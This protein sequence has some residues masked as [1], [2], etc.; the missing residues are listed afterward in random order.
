MPL[1]SNIQDCNYWADYPD[2]EGAIFDI[3]DQQL[4]NKKYHDGFSIK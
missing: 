3:T 2:I 4:K 1:L